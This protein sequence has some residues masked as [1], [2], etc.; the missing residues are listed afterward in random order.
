MLLSAAPAKWVLNCDVSVNLNATAILQGQKQAQ[1]MVGSGHIVLT[2]EVLVP[3]DLAP[4]KV[5]AKFLSG[6]PE[7]FLR[8]T[9]L[10]EDLGGD[11]RIVSEDK[12]FDYQSLREVRLMLQALVFVDPLVVASRQDPCSEATRK[13]ALGT[14]RDLAADSFA[15][16]RED[17]RV[18]E[19]KVGCEPGKGT[20]R[21]P[22]TA[23]IRVPKGGGSVDVVGNGY[24]EVPSQGWRS[25]ARLAG[26]VSHVSDGRNEFTVK[27]TLARTCGLR[28]AR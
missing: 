11:A 3:G 6:V 12:G 8:T 17:T 16:S 24:V 28:P 21:Y 7:G 5:R 10:V 27:G 25:G 20:T 22:Y 13:L 26:S 9:F 19:S 18:T 1:P 4:K 14:I 23:T 15:L 2:A